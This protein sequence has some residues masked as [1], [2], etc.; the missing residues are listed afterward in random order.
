MVGDTSSKSTHTSV[1]KKVGSGT[2][3]GDWGLTVYN[4][5]PLEEVRCAPIS[6]IE[7]I[8]YTL[9]YFKHHKK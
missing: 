6:I 1:K 5:V 9:K 4:Y 8:N 2:E 7:Y 3:L